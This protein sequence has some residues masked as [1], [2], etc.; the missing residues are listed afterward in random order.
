MRD[1][2]VKADES[3]HG[4]EDK[5]QGRLDTL[6][7]VVVGRNSRLGRR[8]RGAGGGLSGGS[9]GDGAGAAV[10]AAAG[11]SRRG[12]G[13]AGSR[14]SAAA[15][16]GSRRDSGRRG[17]SARG[18]SEGE[19]LAEVGLAGAIGDLERIG[20]RRQGRGR[21]PGEGSASGTAGQRLADG[22]QVLG[23]SV[24]ELDGD[25]A[26]GIGPGKGERLAGND[27]EV[28]VG[29]FSLGADNRG[30]STDDGE[31]RELHVDGGLRKERDRFVNTVTMGD[32][33]GE[34]FWMSIT[35][36]KE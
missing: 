30:E 17:A 4:E 19:L 36:I 21:S 34:Y 1:C 23:V 7:V 22:L 11:S 9:G 33:V 26:G 27:V 29:E 25:G 18:T 6:S 16:G 2:L 15:G 13:S 8:G 12:R 32:E 24:D 10:G 14:G 35:S 20:I 3:G 5:G 31:N 28:G